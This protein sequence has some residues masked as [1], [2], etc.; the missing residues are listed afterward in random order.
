MEGLPLGSWVER[1]VHQGW[2]MDA[3]LPSLPL[4]SPQRVVACTFANMS[5]ILYIGGN[6]LNVSKLINFMF[7]ASEAK[8]TTVFSAM[9]FS[10]SEEIIFPI[11]S[12]RA[13]IDAAQT[14]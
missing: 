3:T 4:H 1:V 11:P 14:F 7:L 12:S 13:D 5:S 6:A 2:D 10:S 9:S 8:I